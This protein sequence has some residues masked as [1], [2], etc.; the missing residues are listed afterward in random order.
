[1]QAIQAITP[2]PIATLSN[3]S[4]ILYPALP[5]ADQNL[6]T[7]AL[8]AACDPLD[9]ATDGVIDNAGACAAKFDPATFVFANGQPL[10]CT[11]TKAATCLTAAQID[12]IKKI[13]QGP[14]DARGAPIKAPAGAAART[15]INATIF[16]YLYDGGFM[17]PTGIPS[18]KVGTPT[19]TPGDFAL[20]LGQVPYI[21]VTPANP[22][23][24]PLSFSFAKDLD[25]LNPST[26][27]VSYSASLD[28]AKFKDRGS[29]IIWYHGTSDPGPPVLGTIEY[30][31]QLAARNGDFAQTQAFARLFLVPNMGHCRGGPAT[32]QFDMLTPLVAWVEQGTAPERII[33]SG[34]NFTS[35]PAVRSRPLCPYP[36]EVRYTGTPGGDLAS[37]AN[38]AC[39]APK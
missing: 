34:T 4:P 25:R 27:L 3:G 13:N 26:P 7:S 14:R 31:K 38:Y 12:A 15:P 6:F 23:M 32:D 30:Y 9:G 21:W 8:L 35:A 33:A 1:V 10:Q 5:V 18:R 19:S 29:K 16:G 28:I 39:V 2:A 24:N 11:G 22:E 17:A 36:V 37:A 20:G